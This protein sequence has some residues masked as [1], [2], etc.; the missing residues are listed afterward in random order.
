MQTLEHRKCNHEDLKLLQA[1]TA[2]LQKEITFVKQS[3]EKNK[4]KL[5]NLNEAL[6][7]LKEIQPQKRS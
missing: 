1:R 6:C 7:T 3:N 2:K 5:K 4:E